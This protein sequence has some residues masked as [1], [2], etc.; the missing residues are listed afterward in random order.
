MAA[1]QIS[2]LIKEDSYKERTDIAIGKRNTAA[3]ELIL[4]PTCRYSSSNDPTDENN[5]SPLGGAGY[6][7]DENNNTP[8]GGAGYKADKTPVDL[9]AVCTTVHKEADTNYYTE[10][11]K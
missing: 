2:P 8:L 9:C 5:N 11:I 1:S 3:I 4:T 10:L 6:K 7:A